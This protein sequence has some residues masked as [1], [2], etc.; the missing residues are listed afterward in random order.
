MRTHRALKGFCVDLPRWGVAA[1]PPREP[2]LERCH[3]N[4][5]EGTWQYVRLIAGAARHDLAGGVLIRCDLPSHVPNAAYRLTS[6]TPGPEFFAWAREFFGP[7]RP[8]RLIA[9]GPSAVGLDAEANERG[10]RRVRGDPGMLLDPAGPSAA[11]PP[12][13]TLRSVED[14]T[15]LADFATV[16]C[17]AFRIPRWILPVALPRVPPDD[18]EHR[19]QNRAFVGY[20]AGNAVACASLT[21]TERVAGIANVGTVPSARGRGFGAAITGKAVEMGRELGAD[22]AYLAASEMGFPVYARMG[23]RRVSDYRYWQVPVGFFATMRALR[24]A[25]RLARAARPV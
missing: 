23:F 21:V 20:S 11:I 18:P 3:R 2:S 9:T 8:W 15:T 17:R 13:L 22:V 12:G 24:G 25:R 5:A 1:L 6:E 4:L 10:L 16:W 14:S 7:K 19:A